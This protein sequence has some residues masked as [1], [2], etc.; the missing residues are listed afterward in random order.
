MKQ[1]IGKEIKKCLLD[2]SLKKVMTITVDNTSSIDTTI[3]YFK[4]RVNN[5]GTSVL[6]AE[7]MHARCISIL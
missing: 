7:F 3:A 4:K 5:W 2:R 6:Q 1:A